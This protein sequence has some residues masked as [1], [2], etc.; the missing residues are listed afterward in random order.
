[1]SPPLGCDPLPLPFVWPGGSLGLSLDDARATAAPAPARA[2]TL[3]P[4]SRA[5]RMYFIMRCPFLLGSLWTE[6]T[7]LLYATSGLLC[8]AQFGHAAWIP[9]DWLLAAQDRASEQ[10]S[11]RL[12][13]VLV[14]RVT[15]A[16][17][18]CDFADCLELLAVV[19]ANLHVVRVHAV[20]FDR[21]AA[22]KGRGQQPRPSP[23]C[24]RFKLGS[25]EG[26]ASD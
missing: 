7:D 19:V 16:L 2:V 17:D 8:Y 24:C 13:R 20:P 11:V 3:R 18:C 6:S 10:E 23:L 4:I 22:G 14:K 12:R 15:E 1:M 25:A 26:Q 21:G 5:L 9:G